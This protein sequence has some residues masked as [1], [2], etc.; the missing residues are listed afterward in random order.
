[1]TEV[2]EQAAS[3]A[4]MRTLEVVEGLEKLRA[5]QQARAES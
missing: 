1:M 3:T 2:P 5:G 4:M